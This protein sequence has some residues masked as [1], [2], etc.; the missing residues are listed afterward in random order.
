MSFNFEFNTGEIIQCI[1]PLAPIRSD[2]NEASELETQVLYGQSCEVIERG[3]KSWVKVKIV[4]DQYIGWTDKKHFSAELFSRPYI[5]G[6]LIKEVV[7]VRGKQFLPFGSYLTDEEMTNLSDYGPQFQF[8]NSDIIRLASKW[9]NAP[10]LW[11]GKSILGVDCSG[12]IQL[13]FAFFGIQL[14]RNASQQATLGKYVPFGEHHAG[15]A[16]FFINENGKIIHVGII[17]ENNHIWHA[18]GMVRLDF[19]TCEGIVHCDS[20]VLTHQLHSIKRFF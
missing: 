2:A 14:P 15:D 10:Y 18:S 12:Y 5:L 20:N 19:F 11:G 1:T 9:E 8:S 13:L 16:A 17:A 7:T 6:Q 4:A 3:I